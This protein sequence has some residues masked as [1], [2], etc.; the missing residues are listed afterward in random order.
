MTGEDYIVER[1]AQDPA[2]RE[3]VIAHFERRILRRGDCD[4]WIGL[5]RKSNSGEYGVLTL[6]TLGGRATRKTVAISAHRLAMVL[7]TGGALPKGMVVDH[8]C[9][10]TFCV[11]HLELVTQSEN[12]RRAHARGWN[13]S[14]DAF[15]GDLP[16]F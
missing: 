7:Y 9:P 5:R 2:Y 12:V 14:E 3:R 11:S 15:V 1:M 6:H 10:D 8:T 16:D 13:K 4:V